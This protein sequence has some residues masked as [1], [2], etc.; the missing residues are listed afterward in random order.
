[1]RLW[2]EIMDSQNNRQKFIKNLQFCTDFLIGQVTMTNCLEI[3]QIGSQFNL[4]EVD[5]YINKYLLINFKKIPEL[6]KLPFER[7]KYLLGSNELEN[8]R[9]IDLFYQVRI[10]LLGQYERRTARL[11]NSERQLKDF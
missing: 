4:T 10:E 11:C 5:D 3:G 6:T 1:M 2:T 8:V 9:E 7:L